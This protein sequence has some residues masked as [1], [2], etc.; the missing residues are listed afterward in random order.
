MYINNPRE[1]VDQIQ[2][3]A[4]L[5]SILFACS[6][7]IRSLTGNSKSPRSIDCAVEKLNLLH[8]ENNYASKI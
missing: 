1:N 6:R 8:A 7:D 5:N 2:M 4:N 3:Q